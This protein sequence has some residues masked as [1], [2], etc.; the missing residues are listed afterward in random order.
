MESIC[1]AS[2]RVMLREDE[3]NHHQEG[4]MGNTTWDSTFL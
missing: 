4:G 2:R 1:H 3:G